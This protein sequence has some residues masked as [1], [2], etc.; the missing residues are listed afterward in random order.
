MVLLV[1]HYI[2]V[3]VWTYSTQPTI[4]EFLRQKNNLRII[5]DEIIIAVIQMCKEACGVNTFQS[6]SFDYHLPKTI[7]R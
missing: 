5:P 4:L 7:S 6:P 3:N 1:S 2:L